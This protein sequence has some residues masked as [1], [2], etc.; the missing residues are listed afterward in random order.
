MA[1]NHVRELP[2]PRNCSSA[3]CPSVGQ[4]RSIGQ[5]RGPTFPSERPS[6]WRGL[7]LLSA[8]VLVRVH[9]M[10]LRNVLR[11][12]DWRHRARNVSVPRPRPTCNVD[13]RGR[14]PARFHSCSIRVDSFLCQSHWHFRHHPD[15]TSSRPNRRW[16]RKG[17]RVTRACTSVLSAVPRSEVEKAQWVC[18]P[19]NLCNK[20]SST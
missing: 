8:T 20:A 1:P 4:V 2:L 10:L 6:Y 9:S 3:P 19:V 11:C 15:R 7:N 18:A 14:L 16:S 17:G 13:Y 5:L 12:C